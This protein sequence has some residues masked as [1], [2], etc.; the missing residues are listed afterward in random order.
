MLCVLFIQFYAERGFKLVFTTTRPV[1]YESNLKTR[2][3]EF[4]LQCTSGHVPSLFRN[5][6]QDYTKE[7]E[8]KYNAS[9]SVLN[10]PVFP[11]PLL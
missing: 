4:L 7:A 3:K 6:K 1:N 8:R 9:F 11:S 10:H 5:T 2:E